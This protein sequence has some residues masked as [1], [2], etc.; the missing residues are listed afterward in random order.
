[1]KV[2]HDHRLVAFTLDVRG[3]ETYNAYVK[4]THTGETILVRQGVASVEWGGDITVDNLI[5]EGEQSSSAS[6]AGPLPQSI[7][8]PYL[9]FYTAPDAEELARGGRRPS[10]V[11]HQ[12][13]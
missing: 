2:S 7:G 12:P 4:D 5:H 13:S 1:M 3:D 6:V 8:T 10:Q 9:L 11:S